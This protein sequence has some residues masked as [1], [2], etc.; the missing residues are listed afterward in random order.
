MILDGYGQCVSPLQARGWKQAL[1]GWSWQR[2][3][4]QHVH[5]LCV[6]PFGDLILQSHPVCVVS[7]QS[8]VCARHLQDG[9]ERAARSKSYAAA[10]ETHES[11]GPM[12]VSW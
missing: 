3:V 7:K 9:V 8:H 10:S 2:H 11:V 4:Q 12:K 6:V 5:R 1:P